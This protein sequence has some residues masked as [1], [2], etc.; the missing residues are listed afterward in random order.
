MVIPVG[1][2]FAVQQLVL[3]TKDDNGEVSTRQLMPVR[4]VPL[5][6]GP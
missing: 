6:R 4:F 5:T 1:G 3:L 2:R